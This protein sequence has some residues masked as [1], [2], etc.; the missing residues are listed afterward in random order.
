MVNLRYHN[1]LSTP[2]GKKCTLYE[3]IN[4]NYLVLIK[5]IEAK[6]VA[7]FYKCLDEL[8]KESIP[9]FDEYNLIDKAYIYLAYCFY[10]IHSSVSYRSTGVVERE[11]SLNEILNN[12]EEDF[13]NLEKE[14]KFKNLVV[15]C[16]YPRTLIIS[17]ESI[18]ID[19]ASALDSVNDIKFKNNEE[20]I[21]FL[22]S[23][24]PKWSM[25]LEMAIR[26]DF[27]VL[28]AMFRNGVGPFAL[29]TEKVNILDG[30]LFDSIMQIYREPLAD[31]YKVLY[32][33]I[34]Y[35]RMSYDS[36]MRMTPLE[37]RYIFNQFAEDKER[38]AQEQ[39]NQIQRSRH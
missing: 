39:Q 10:S 14:Y 4:E 30:G 24:G 36:Y 35:L 29:D 3:I 20:R 37:T 13:T 11:I 23:I 38:Q 33:H 7:N 1:F 26:R 2:S 17:D 18:L 27:T 25:Q 34:E 32:Y 12:I 22:R 19:Y 8:I 6:D 31:Y 5:F 28:C 9:D 16:S 15:K 21:N